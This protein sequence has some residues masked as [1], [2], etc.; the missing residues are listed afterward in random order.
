MVVG[1]PRDFLEVDLTPYL[2]DL[3]VVGLLSRLP[4]RRLDPLFTGLG[5]R[6]PALAT[7]S[8]PNLFPCLLDLVPVGLPVG[9]LLEVDLVPLFTGL[10]GCRLALTT[11][12]KTLQ[13][14]SYAHCDE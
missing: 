7:S 10:G 14:N 1:L 11:S 8:E 3:V 13:Q 4:R 5:G 12:S 9:L 6:R 2:P